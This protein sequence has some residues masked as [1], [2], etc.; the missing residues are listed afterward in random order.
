[1][2]LKGVERGDMGRVT[3]HVFLGPLKEEGSLRE[4][5]RDCT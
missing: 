5:D 2:T 3:T 1:M 4:E